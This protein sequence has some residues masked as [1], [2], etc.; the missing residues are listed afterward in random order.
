MCLLLRALPCSGWAL[1]EPSPDV[2]F[3]LVPGEDPAL[4][5]EMAPGMNK[6][7]SVVLQHHVCYICVVTL[8]IN[9]N[10]GRRSLWS[11]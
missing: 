4:V 7:L 5:S 3:C 9:A 6:D 8:D 1:S 10:L 11:Q 2:D